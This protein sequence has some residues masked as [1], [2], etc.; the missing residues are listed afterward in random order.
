MSSPRTV[1]FRIASEKV[2]ELDLIAKAMDRDRS[3]LINEAVEGYL[4]EQRRFA[5]M[6]EEGLEASR[7]EELIDDEEVGRRIESW[8]RNEMREK[9]AEQKKVGATA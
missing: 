2:A 3:Y 1:S 7:K 8:N 5:A 9:E 6:V 4:S